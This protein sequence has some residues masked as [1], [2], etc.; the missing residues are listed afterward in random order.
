MLPDGKSHDLGMHATR[1][2]HTKQPIS[3]TTLVRIGQGGPSF[4]NRFGRKVLPTSIVPRVIHSNIA[5]FSFLLNMPVR[6]YAGDSARVARVARGTSALEWH[7]QTPGALTRT[8][9]KG[10]R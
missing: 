1:T 3:D 2:M 8:S 5:E 9:E 10:R 4:G 6:L 7:I